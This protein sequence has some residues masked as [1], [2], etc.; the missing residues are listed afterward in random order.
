M[1]KQWREVQNQNIQQQKQMLEMT[2]REDFHRRLI[3]DLEHQVRTLKMQV[4]QK[5]LELQKY[6]SNQ[7]STLNDRE[8]A[9]H[10]NV[11]QS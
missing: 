1:N 10:F 3:T 9:T 8:K 2:Q 11:F 7:Y 5:D 4:D 6:K